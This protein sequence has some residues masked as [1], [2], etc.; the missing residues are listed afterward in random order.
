MRLRIAFT[1]LFLCGPLH[2]AVDCARTSLGT[3]TLSEYLLEYGKDC[4]D[5]RAKS[6]LGAWKVAESERDLSKMVPAWHDL[7]D[8]FSA[9]ALRTPQSGLSKSYAALAERAKRAGQSLKANLEA[10]N[11]NQHSAPYASTAWKQ[12][13]STD[14]SDLFFPGV[15]GVPPVMIQATADQDCADRASTLCRSALADGKELMLNWRLADRLSFPVSQAAIE[16]IGEVVAAK[17][18]LWDRYLYDSKPMLPLDFIVTDW[19]DGRWQK[20]DQYPDGFREPPDTQWFLLHPSVGVEQLSAA[21]DGQELKPVLV[22][23]LFGAN[24][25]R[26]DRRW[27]DA[28]L[29]R[30]LSGASFALSYADREGIRD[31]GA[32]VIL[33]FEN[34]YSIGLMRYDSKTSVLFSLDVANLFREKYREKYDAFKRGVKNTLF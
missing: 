6:Q 23:E 25:W 9:L 17:K 24:R 20:S 5:A 2:A 33:T 7:S 14:T 4:V 8:R 31:T 26:E 16:R 30:S 27:I 15:A 34:V 3:E 10:G 32:G 19:L 21:P 18:A 13:R 29:L 11:V 1:A 28:P 22:L 12:P